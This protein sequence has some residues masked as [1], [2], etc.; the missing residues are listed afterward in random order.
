MLYLG[1]AGLAGAGKDTVAQFILGQRPT[2]VRVGNADALKLGA[3]AMAMGRYPEP[4]EVPD[5]DALVPGRNFTWR[6]FYQMLGTEGVRTLFGQDFWLQTLELAITYQRETVRGITGVVIP[7]VRFENEAHFVRAHGGT[8]IH[9]IR[10]G[11]P[12]MAHISEA[13]IESQRRDLTLRNNGGL[14]ALQVKVQRLLEGVDK[15]K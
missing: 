2:M 6:Y 7:D 9:V 11:T 1:L 5:K 15:T 8:I 12:K 13:G 4:D 3:F 14:E 10:P